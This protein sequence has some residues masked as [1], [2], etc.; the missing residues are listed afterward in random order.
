MGL[1]IGSWEIL[2]ILI[3]ALIILGPSKLT[4]FARTLGKTVRAIKKA[5]ADLTT[6][7]TR[8]MDITRN[9]LTSPPKEESNTK[10]TESPPTKGKAELPG[11][12]DQP[13][14]SGEAPAA[15]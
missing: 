12:D 13:A 3:L 9:E 2:L 7:V 8:E 11:K 1:G 5:S 4:D 6:A 15:K 10:S 14:K